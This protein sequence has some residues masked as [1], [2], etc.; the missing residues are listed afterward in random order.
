MA[1]TETPE[2]TTTTTRPAERPSTAAPASTTAHGSGRATASLVLGIL[3]IPASM[4]PIL[5]IALGVIGL[6]LGMTARNDM[7]RAGGPVSG[8]AKAGVI[9]ASIGIGLSIVFWIASA[10]IV[11]SNR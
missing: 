5:G 10:A 9:L 7:R 1:A 11:M 4:F 2:R 6:V 8:R 3:S